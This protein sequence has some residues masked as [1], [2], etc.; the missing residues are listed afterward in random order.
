MSNKSYS[1]WCFLRQ[2]YLWR[3]VFHA[4]L[5][6]LSHRTFENNVQYNKFLI[7]CVIVSN[8]FVLL[9]LHCKAFV[10]LNWRSMISLID[11]FDKNAWR[12]SRMMFVY[13]CNAYHSDEHNKSVP[14]IIFFKFY[15]IISGYAFLTT[16]IILFDLQLERWL[17]TMTF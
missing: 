3:C 16:D 4:M 12:P 7:L 2:T 8:L 11:R 10:H 5:R 14:E 13:W 15:K 9:K 17:R 6:S 1:E